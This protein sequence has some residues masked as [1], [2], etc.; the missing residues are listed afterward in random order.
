MPILPLAERR[1]AAKMLR[2]ESGQLLREP[3][4][5]PSGLYCPIL[6]R[7]KGPSIF[8]AR[9]SSVDH[10]GKRSEMSE[11]STC[12]RNCLQ[13]AMIWRRGLSQGLSRLSL[14]TGLEQSHPHRK[15]PCCPG[16]IAGEQPTD[17]M[18]VQLQAPGPSM[19]VPALYTVHFP[20]PSLGDHAVAK[21]PFWAEDIVSFQ[22]SSS[23][24]ARGYVLCYTPFSCNSL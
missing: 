11:S 24:L 14:G 1:K 15:L 2:C 22:N 23:L 13:S 8:L 12:G 6:V 17:Y 19:I 5:L 18:A 3:Y 9:R 21:E 16:C 4:L 20:L 10:P 7:V